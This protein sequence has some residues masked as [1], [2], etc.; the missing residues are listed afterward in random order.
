MDALFALDKLVDIKTTKAQESNNY[1]AEKAPEEDKHETR[2]RERMAPA[3]F[4]EATTEQ[5]ISRELFC[6]AKFTAEV[7][8]ELIFLSALNVLMSITAFLGNIVILAALRKETSLH[9]PSKLLYRNLAV[10]DL[11]VAITAEPL[12]ITYW[13]SVVNQRW[14]L[15]H[16]ANVAIFVTAATLCSASLFTVT[17]ISMD[18]LLALLLGLKYRQVVTLKKTSIT[19]IVLWILSIVATASYFWKPFIYTWLF[20]AGVF[21]PCVVVS[22]LSHTKIFL[23]L[24]QKEKHVREQQGQE[25]PEGIARY[26]KAVSSSLWLLVALVVCYLPY[27]I[28]A[29]LTPYKGMSLSVYL[30][31]AFTFTFVFLNSSLNP[32][33]Y[34]WKIQEVR[35]AVKDTT[36]QLLFSTSYTVQ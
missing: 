17:A 28:T 21:L 30:A 18:R 33:L 3:N 5:R 16:F 24:R 8:D 15:C 6:S 27:G 2:T 14:D 26:R 35:Q 34:C 7:H 23:T 12:T 13:M 22:C 36:R 31:R 32:V 9:P 20:E 25:I 29:P 4:T 19:V 1:A 11:C 10:T